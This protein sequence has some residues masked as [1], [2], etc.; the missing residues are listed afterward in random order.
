MFSENPL[1]EKEDLLRRIDKYLFD[2]YLFK[3]S[4]DEELR[5]TSDIEIETIIKS[6]N[7]KF[8][9]QDK[10]PYQ[11]WD[12]KIRAGTLLFD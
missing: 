3:R 9:D 5:E 7:V 2:N 6:S 8:E 11:Y 1:G 10:G 12:S 4:G